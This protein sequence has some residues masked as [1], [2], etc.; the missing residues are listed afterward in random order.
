MRGYASLRPGRTSSCA[1]CQEQCLQR[2]FRNPYL[3]TMINGLRVYWLLLDVVETAYRWWLDP[4]SDSDQT[5]F[6]DDTPITAGDTDPGHGQAPT[7]TLLRLPNATSCGLDS[8]THRIIPR[9]MIGL[10]TVS[11]CLSFLIS[12]AISLSSSTCTCQAVD[13][14]N[15][16]RKYILYSSSQFQ[17]LLASLHV[18]VSDSMA[19]PLASLPTR[20]CVTDTMP[21]QPDR[22]DSEFLY[23]NSHQ[24]FTVR[25]PRSTGLSA[26]IRETPGIAWCEIP[27]DGRLGY[28][29]QTV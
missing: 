29:K 19:I 11:K 9:C 7:P 8:L 2:L 5:R 20:R 15:T 27:R 24:R 6:Q 28:S 25:A 23:I 1:G 12:F 16:I 3:Q 21:R 14:E 18:R 26:N 13:P 17:T 22:A 10:S 4:D